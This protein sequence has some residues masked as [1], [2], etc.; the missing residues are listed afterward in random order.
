M[1]VFTID[2]CSLQ[3]WS[4]SLVLL[5]I[6][7]FQVVNLR[8]AIN[9]IVPSSFFTIQYL[10]SPVVLPFKAIGQEPALSTTLEY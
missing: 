5:S 2:L 1:E 6:M 3:K 10:F 8:T 4:V 9:L 7:E